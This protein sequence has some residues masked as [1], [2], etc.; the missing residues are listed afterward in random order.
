MWNKPE[1]FHENG[2]YLQSLLFL[3][4]MR[5]PAFVLD[6]NGSVRFWNEQMSTFSEVSVD[7]VLNRSIYELVDY[8][9]C[10]SNESSNLGKPLPE[11]DIYSSTSLS[12]PSCWRFRHFNTSSDSS[13]TWDSFRIRMISYQVDVGDGILKDWFIC[14]AEKDDGYRCIEVKETTNLFGDR[15]IILEQ[16]ASSIQEF[17]DTYSVT[18]EN[19]CEEKRKYDRITNIFNFSFLDVFSMPSFIMDSSGSVRY[20]N[21][22]M[23]YLTGFSENEIQD[24]SILSRGS[25]FIVWHHDRCVTSKRML[26]EA[27]HAVVTKT[28]STNSDDDYDSEMNIIST[29]R[30]VDV[31]VR[32]KNSEQVVIQSWRM[33]KIRSNE[34]IAVV[35]VTSSINETPLSHQG[36]DDRKIDASDVS[37]QS[38]IHSYLHCAS[39]SL[40]SRVF[41]QCEKERNTLIYSETTV[42]STNVSHH[43][44]WRQNSCERSK[45]YSLD[46]KN[47]ASAE[48]ASQTSNHIISDECSLEV[49]N[50]IRANELLNVIDTCEMLVFGVDCK[51]IVNEWNNQCHALLGF[52]RDEAVG[53]PFA[54]TFVSNH[55]AKCSID[56]VLQY[57]L[58]GIGTPSFELV[59]EAKT[60]ESRFLLL[61]ASP[62]RK[63]TTRQD[64]GISS[65]RI[66]GVVFFGLD[67]TEMFKHDRAIATMA[68][69]LRQLIDTANA[70]IFGIDSDG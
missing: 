10:E 58:E 34:N 66:N 19:Y 53:K 41:Q 38:T 43:L 28:N 62:R 30:S 22:K 13:L 2:D 50:P 15:A 18:D 33:N 69:E 65:N 46:L 7:I 6:E 16:E 49:T 25:D 57:A 37:T 24:C 11:I 20:W 39:E 32:H 68:R 40:E 44:K 59:I 14:F 29:E 47:Q 12:T 8:C 60:G 5:I 51:G 36:Q 27:L 64:A 48:N 45:V 54:T 4:R 23:N 1:V 31:V 55:V 17:T 26:I 21:K 42:N 56:E 3:N 67:M 9:S 61:A 52:Q 70:P 63:I 35:F